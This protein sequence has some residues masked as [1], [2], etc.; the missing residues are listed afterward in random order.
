MISL[1]F[2]GATVLTQYGYYSHF[3]VPSDFVDASLKANIIQFF[4]LF[5]LAQALAG[6]M[7]W[8][9]WIVIIVIA[10]II[11]FVCYLSP[12]WSTALA[13]AAIVLLGLSLVKWYSFGNLWAKTKLTYTIIAESCPSIGPEK[14]YV[15]LGSNEWKGVFVPVEATTDKLLGGYLIKDVADLGCK[16]EEKNIGVLVK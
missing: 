2:Y 8:W 14:L 16:F 13:I 7:R 11:F 1:Y 12:K 6:L 9:L 3:D 5:R 15:M 4:E 10:I